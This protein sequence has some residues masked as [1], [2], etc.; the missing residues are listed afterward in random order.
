MVDKVDSQRMEQGDFME[1]EAN[2]PAYGWG[3]RP[4]A[5]GLSGI[6][7]RWEYELSVQIISF[8]LI[9]CC[10]RIGPVVSNSPSYKRGKCDDL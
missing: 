10:R 5:M 2:Y 9:M 1:P 8:I 6:T 3:N 7:N 4:P